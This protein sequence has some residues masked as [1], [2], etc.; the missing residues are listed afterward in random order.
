[1]KDF[2]A[3][4]ITILNEE[5]PGPPFVRTSADS[6]NLRAP[7]MF[8]INTKNIVGDAKGKVILK[9]LL[10][11]LAPSISAASITSL[12]IDCSPERIKSIDNPE[13]FQTSR[14]STEILEY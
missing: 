4:S 11:L 9:N 3:M 1:V 12:L 7:V 2:S 8:I 10:N 6:Y 13:F 5:S 14:K